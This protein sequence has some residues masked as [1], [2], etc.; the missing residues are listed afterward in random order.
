MPP[1]L[2]VTDQGPVHHFD[3][4]SADFYIPLYHPT[5]ALCRYDISCS[6][7]L[8]GGGGIVISADVFVWI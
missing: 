7:T 2:I 4:G 5:L 1:S 6:L 8:G 3:A